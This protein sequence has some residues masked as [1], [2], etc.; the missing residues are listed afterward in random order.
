MLDF[1]KE[2]ELQERIDKNTWRNVGVIDNKVENIGNYVK[3]LDQGN[4]LWWYI[5][6]AALALLFTE[7]LL[8]GI[9]KM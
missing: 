1:F 3:K 5:I 6:I 7:S 8:T 2:T 4:Q 9:W